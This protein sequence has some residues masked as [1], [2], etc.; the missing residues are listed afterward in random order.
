[1]RTCSGSLV[2]WGKGTNH[3][4]ITHSVV[5]DVVIVDVVRISANVATAGVAGDIAHS[6]VPSFLRSIL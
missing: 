6:T 4:I 5:I 1:M 3:S 2:V